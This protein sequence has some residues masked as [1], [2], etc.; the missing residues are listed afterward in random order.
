MDETALER[1]R[2]RL[3]VA[4]KHG[5]GRTR[6]ATLAPSGAA[7][8]Y[9]PRRS[10][11]DVAEIVLVN[12]AGG[13]TGGDRLDVAIRLDANTK[14]VVT[15]QGAERVYR[16]LD[17]DARLDVRLEVGPEASLAWLPQ[18]TILFDGGRLERRLTLN[19]DTN[20]ACLVV[21]AVVLGRTA[22][23]ERVRR[24]RLYDRWRLRRGG[25]VVFAEALRLDGD[26]E[27]RTAAAAEL[28]GNRAFA[29]LVRLGPDAEGL[30]DPLRAALRRAIAG[31]GIEAA[32]GVVDSVLV[33]RLLAGDGFALKRGIKAAL[34]AVH[35]AGAPRAWGL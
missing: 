11:P 1:T 24:G 25:R 35:P 34:N 3:E 28:G 20:A 7:K 23:G 4:L 15:T 16:A 31:G 19:A 32:A 10:D 29:T 21:E 14:A 8:A 18:E 2:G 5:A 22:Y 27:R 13:L 30:L 12:T 6:L 26:L 9:L 17:G 33:A